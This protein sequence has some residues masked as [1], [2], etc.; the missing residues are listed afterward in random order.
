LCSRT[1]GGV[2]C[3]SPS[4]SIRLPRGPRNN[5]EKPSRGTMRRAI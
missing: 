3:T 5:C 1:T 2:L 4:R